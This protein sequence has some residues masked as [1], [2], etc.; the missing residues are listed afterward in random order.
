MVVKFYFFLK[1][2]NIRLLDKLIV[3]GIEIAFDQGK[4][5]VLSHI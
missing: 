2:L 4:E 5:K 1:P 3:L